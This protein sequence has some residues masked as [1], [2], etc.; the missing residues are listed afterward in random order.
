MKM[1][2]LPELVILD[3]GHGNCS[4]L[5]DPEG[6][7]VIDCA[8]GI[9]LWEF[10][11]Q[12]G[13]KEITHVFVSHADSDHVDGISL[14]LADEE[15][16]VHNLYV[17]PDPKNT[18]TWQAFRVAIA[19]ARKT[20]G[21]RVS[22]SL[23][24]D[25]PGKVEIGNVC[26]EVLYP[27]PEQ[28]TGGVGGKTLDGKRTLTSNSLSAVL[29]IIHNSYRVALLAGDVDHLGLE[30]LLNQHTDITATILVFP[31]HGGRP[32]GTDAKAFAQKLCSLVCPQLIL[33]SN[34]R[35]HFGNPR[36]EIVEGARL[37]VSDCYVMC[38]QLS[39]TCA[40]TTEH[41]DFSH[42]SDLPSSGLS[43]DKCCG[44]SVVITLNGKD[45]LASNSL[46]AHMSF[47]KALPTPLCWQKL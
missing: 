6:V 47:T 2:D 40:D 1:M 39:E 42:L 31:H 20:Q 23:T 38:T 7:V 10:L 26:V 41:L 22:N 17:N 33:F 15:I 27:S 46:A 19:A 14:L 29:A 34:G 44:G 45:T 18:K 11:K 13:I 36:Q 16:M 5:L 35:G 4:V 25:Q 32:S 28:A 9:I 12:R 21:T 8:D 30:D 24:I 3:V 43:Q 37:A